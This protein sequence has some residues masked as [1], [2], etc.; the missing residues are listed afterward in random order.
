M[1]LYPRLS[2]TTSPTPEE[3]NDDK[4]I[5]KIEE[6]IEDFQKHEVSTDPNIKKE[7]TEDD[8]EQNIK[9]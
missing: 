5:V 3:H 1:D 8:S 4:D 7:K 9:R 6:E 2:V